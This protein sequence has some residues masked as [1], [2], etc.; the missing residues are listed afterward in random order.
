MRAVVYRRTMKGA[1]SGPGEEV[2]GPTIPSGE[3][4]N[5]PDEQPGSVPPPLSFSRAS[6]GCMVQGVKY[7]L[8]VLM[9]YNGGTT[10]RLTGVVVQPK[11]NC[12]TSLFHTIVSQNLH[13]AQGVLCG[14]VF[15]TLQLPQVLIVGNNVDEF[16]SLRHMAARQ[17]VLDDCLIT[18]DGELM[19]CSES[20]KIGR[21]NHEAHPHV[22]TPL[23]SEVGEEVRLELSQSGGGVSN[24]I[25]LTLLAFS[26][27]T[28]HPMEATITTCQGQSVS[29]LCVGPVNQYHIWSM[30]TAPDADV[31]RI[32]EGSNLISGNQHTVRVVSDSSGSDG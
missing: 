8:D 28:L 16:K 10:P 22:V 30:Q 21:M 23:L 20:I 25:R 18:L 3:Q 1:S 11:D 4:S 13:G 27:Q 9:R 14:V 5:I 17:P 12:G 6:H 31:I 29:G 19:L 7:T 24:I 32:N 2:V 26:S 15:P